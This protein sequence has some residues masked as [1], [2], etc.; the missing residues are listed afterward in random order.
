MT[1]LWTPLLRLRMPIFR[2]AGRQPTKSAIAPLSSAE[3]CSGTSAAADANALIER[4]EQA[5]APSASKRN[6]LE[7]LRAALA[8]AIERIKAT[9]LTESESRG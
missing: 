3:L 9:N 6:V 5:I 7:Q 2:A 8:Q 1:P 4:I